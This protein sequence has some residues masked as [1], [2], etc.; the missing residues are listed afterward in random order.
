VYP[1]NYGHD[2]SSAVHVFYPPSPFPLLLS[3]S[4]LVLFAN[5]TPRT[6]RLASSFRSRLIVKPA[7]TLSPSRIPLYPR[8]E[9]SAKFIPRDSARRSC[10][11]N[12]F[13]VPV[14]PF[15]VPCATGGCFPN[16]AKGCGRSV[17]LTPVALARPESTFIP[18]WFGNFEEHP[19]SHGELFQLRVRGGRGTEE[20]KSDD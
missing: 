2:V 6:S 15:L 5:F 1:C 11:P 16:R 3:P 18:C 13:R 17:G 8:L 19:V 10:P 12:H 7:D 9:P 20:E 14:A 4:P